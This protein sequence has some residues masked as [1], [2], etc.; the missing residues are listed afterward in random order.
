MELNNQTKV[1][2]DCGIEKPIADFYTQNKKR[3]DGTVY[4][5]HNPECK[6]CSTKRSWDW[7]INNRKRRS[8]NQKNYAR[9]TKGNEIKN[10]ASKNWREKGKQKE[11]QRRNLDKLKEYALL[12]QNKVH[13]FTEE[14]WI[15]CKNYFNFECAYCGFHEGDSLL[16]YNQQLHRDHVIHDGSNDIENCVPACLSCNVSK[17]DNAFT[18]W[19]NVNNPNYSEE[20]LNKIIN[21]TTNDFQSITG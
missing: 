10:R 3:K 7:Q 14:E 6:E 13:V 11:W 4:I 17:R 18:E 16:I 15:E 19:Y 2:K 5:Y 8:E 12:R 1:C 21:W 20:R 9:T